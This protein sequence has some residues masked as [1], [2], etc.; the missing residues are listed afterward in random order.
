MSGDVAGA[1]A[2]FTSAVGREAVERA[3]A[4]V[5][6]GIGDE[7]VAG[8]GVYGDAVGDGDVL[9]GAVGYEVVGHHFMCADV[10]DAVGDGVFLGVVAPIGGEVVD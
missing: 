4:D 6:F 7:Y 8:Y 2:P 10:N 5:V 1:D 3:A 9:V